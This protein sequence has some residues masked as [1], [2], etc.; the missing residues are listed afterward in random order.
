MIVGFATKRERVTIKRYTASHPGGI[1]Y[2]SKTPLSEADI[3]KFVNGYSL[4]FVALDGSEVNAGDLCAFEYTDSFSLTGWLKI[5][6]GF[7]SG[8]LLER[9]G[10]DA[11]WRLRLDTAVLYLDLIHDLGLSDMI[12]CHAPTTLSVDEWYFWGVTYD[13]G[14]VGS[15]GM[16]FYL[17]GALDGCTSI[18]ES[19]TGTIIEPSIDLMLGEDFTGWQDEIGVYNGVLT[20]PE[21]ANLFVTQVPK[22]LKRF[23]AP[24]PSQLRHWWRMGDSFTAPDQMK[25]EVTGNYAT[26]VNATRDTDVPI[27]I[28]QDPFLA[29]LVSYWKFNEGP[30]S[31]GNS[32]IDSRLG[33]SLVCS[34][35]MY[36]R[37]T[38]LIVEPGAS[39][40]EGTGTGHFSG[41]ATIAHTSKTFSLQM[42]FVQDVSQSGARIV[43]KIG[44]TVGTWL[45]I[46]L[47]VLFIRV[48]IQGNSN[49][50][51]YITAGATNHLVIISDAVSVRVWLNG[52]LVRTFAAFT[53]NASLP[54]TIY[55]GGTGSGDTS[56]LDGKM[57]EY[58]FWPGRV[59]TPTEVAELRN[60]GSGRPIVL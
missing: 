56:R 33:A 24:S 26:I 29:N 2:K 52:S 40:A 37:A 35:T 51:A 25:D 21:M 5:E 45:Q 13:G 20:A 17:A 19:V 48:I 28:P 16:K 54:A 18:S 31:N 9:M 1:G 55:I 32:L 14:N 8:T 34:G 38:P 44:D 47:A 36:K 4:K 6:T 3:M 59:L 60:G 11:G 49:A 39:C 15:T 7:N 50:T 43:F 27:V 46:Q 58:A 53:A 12:S 23:S 42:W 41:A 30:W 10:T 57:D 22:H